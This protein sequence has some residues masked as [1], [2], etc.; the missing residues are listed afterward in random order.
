MTAVNQAVF[1]FAPFAFGVLRD[2]TG[3][4]AV[5]FS[6]AAAIRLAAGVIVLAGREM[7]NPIHTHIVRNPNTN[8]REPR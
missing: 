1:A 4:Y 7:L 6:A 3:N 5:A 2:P 8:P